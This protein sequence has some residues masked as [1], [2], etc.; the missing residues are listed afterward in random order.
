[1]EYHPIPKEVV[2]RIKEGNSKVRRWVFERFK[3]EPFPELEKRKEVEGVALVK[4]WPILG[5]EK[6]LG[7]WDSDRRLP[8]FPSLKF[9]HDAYTTYTYLEFNPSL[10]DDVIF[11]NGELAEDKERKRYLKIV[12]RFRSLTGI[13]TKVLV[14]SRHLPKKEDVIGKGLGLSASA[15]GAAA[16]GLLLAA[17]YEKE[18]KN[19]RFLSWLARHLSG[20]GTSSAVGG[21]SVWFG[22]PGVEDIESY[23]VKVDDGDWME[24][25]VVPIPKQ[26]FKTASAHKAAVNS[27][28]YWE[29]AR[30]KADWVLRLLD[31]ISNKD[32]SSVGQHAERDGYYLTMLLGTGGNTT[33]V[34]VLSQLFREKVLSLRE[35][36]LIEAYI[37]F[38]TGPS[39]AILVRK[40]DGIK[41]IELLKSDES[42]LRTFELVNYSL[43]MGAKFDPY[44]AN[45][46][47]RP[48]PV[49]KEK[50]YVMEGI[51]KVEEL[52]E[53]ALKEFS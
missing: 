4:S 39:P 23:A 6:Y 29:W 52:R 41:L 8:Y 5:I 10:K 12:E 28:W 31:A 50:E 16:S 44:I 36:G 27:P 37:T 43:G 19:N 20:S 47:G 38:D 25:V 40:G 46:A 49:E 14:I 22:Y 32:F 42:F 34:N 15:S 3:E 33:N 51:L 18:F 53:K 17:G 7:M 45:A 48:Q 24:L 13:E 2:E 30:D 21:F 9:S 35:A 11:F 26:G 1:M